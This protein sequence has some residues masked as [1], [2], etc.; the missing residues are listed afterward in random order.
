MRWSFATTQTHRIHE[1]SDS[2]QTTPPQMFA[3]VRARHVRQSP[4]AAI[5]ISRYINRLLIFPCTILKFACYS[6]LRRTLMQATSRQFRLGTPT[7]FASPV[8]HLGTPAFN[9]SKTTFSFCVT[10]D[11]GAPENPMPA[12]ASAQTRSQTQRSIL[13]HHQPQAS[14]SAPLTPLARLFH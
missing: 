13:R 2:P 12:A 7:N 4:A 8:R 5:S 3:I 1:D 14:Q 10:H 6:C 11:T 9:S